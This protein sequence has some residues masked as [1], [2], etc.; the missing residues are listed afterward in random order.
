M[1]ISQL[2]PDTPSKV[3]APDDDEDNSEFNS[4]NTDQFVRL[5]NYH[6]KNELKIKFHSQLHLHSLHFVN[7]QFHNIIVK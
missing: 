1:P 2:P 7:L 4:N 5:F 6:P 3:R